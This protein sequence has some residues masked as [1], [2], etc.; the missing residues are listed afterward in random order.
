M[1]CASLSLHLLYIHL[2]KAR[3]AGQLP[4]IG[5]GEREGR[6]RGEN[7]RGIR[8]QHTRDVGRG[9]LL[10]IVQAL[11]SGYLFEGRGTT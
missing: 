9:W 2:V 6:L 5:E 8:Y 3:E 11:G 1:R 10:Y 4:G 7:K